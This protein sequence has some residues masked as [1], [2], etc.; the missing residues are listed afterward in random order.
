M[1]WTGFIQKSKLNRT[2]KDD[3]TDKWSRKEEKTEL[4]RPGGRWRGSNPR[5]KGHYRFHGGFALYWALTPL[6]DN[7]D[8][9]G[10]VAKMRRYGMFVS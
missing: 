5:Q 3:P 8:D 4:E 6:D 10:T 7:D 2:C 1:L 9:V